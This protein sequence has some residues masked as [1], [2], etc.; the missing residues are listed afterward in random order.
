ML[1]QFREA[2]GPEALLPALKA[3]GL[4]LDDA[5]CVF[6]KA[7][8]QPVPKGWTAWQVMPT[9]KRKEAFEQPSDEIP[10][11]PCG[12]LGLAVDYIGFFMVPDTNPGR[13]LFVNLGQDGTMID[14][15]SVTLSD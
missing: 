11:P 1:R 10:E 7:E 3:K 14:I 5:E 12:E 4:V 9:G 15:G 8:G 2:A 6:A 13:I